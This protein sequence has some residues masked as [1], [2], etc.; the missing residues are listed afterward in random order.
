MW[1]QKAA[2]E[3]Y[4]YYSDSRVQ[5]AMRSSVWRIVEQGANTAIIQL[6]DNWMMEVIYG[7][8]FVS[9]IADELDD[10]G[11]P[12][13]ARYRFANK[14][15]DWAHDELQRVR[16]F[17]AEQQR[18]RR[19]AGLPK[20]DKAYRRHGCWLTDA[21]NDFVQRH[22]DRYNESRRLVDDEWDKLAQ[23]IEELHPPGRFFKGF[24]IDENFQIEVRT[25]FEVCSM[26]EGSGKVTNPNIDC[27][28]VSREDFYDDPDFEEEYFSGSYDII[29]PHCA[30]KRVEA[31]PQF[32]E[33]LNRVIEDFNAADAEH[34]AERCAE[35]RMGA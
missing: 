27:G 33:W 14:I 6:D 35:L 25:K 20:P 18:K 26:C 16:R 11:D 30:G 8:E 4:N 32:P 5:A 17:Y 24:G 31:I 21:E 15:R 2:L 9:R 34:V 1:S 19:E 22:E 3:N 23:Y 28:G 29:C 12:V 7:D 13:A 10:S